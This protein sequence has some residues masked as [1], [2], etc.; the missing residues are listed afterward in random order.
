M[1]SDEDPANVLRLLQEQ[2]IAYVA[3]DDGLRQGTTV[4]HLNEDVFRSN[5]EVAFDDP[6]GT[7]GH[8]AIYRVPPP[9]TVG[10]SPGPVGT[11]APTGPPPSA[12]S[13]AHAPANMFTAGTD[14]AAGAFVRPR[15]IAVQPDGTVLIADSGNHLIERYAADGTYVGAIGGF[16]N[17]PGQFNEPN[18]VV[19]DSHGHVFVADT[20][21]HR[22][23][24][25]DERDQ[26]VR[27]WSGPDIH[28]YGPRDLATNKNG[29]LYILDQGHARVVVLAADGGVTTIR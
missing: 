12:A 17:G 25:F 20:L 23:Q 7:Y 18:G 8:I 11:P 21:N 2:G 29:S 15:G 6:E 28:F 19:V 4:D 10:G 26:F 5:F 13:S 16:G 14:G 3:I 9:T 24:E 22:L 27:E 1:L